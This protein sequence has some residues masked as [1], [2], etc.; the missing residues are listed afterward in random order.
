M[1]ARNSSATSAEFR[2]GRPSARAAGPEPSLCGRSWLCGVVVGCLGGHGSEM[3]RMVPCPG[4]E[5][6]LSVPSSVL[7]TLADVSQSRA[8]GSLCLVKPAAVV[9][10]PHDEHP[11]VV[12]Q[13]KFDLRGGACV[14]CDVLDRFRAAEVNGGLG[15]VGAARRGPCDAHPIGA[16]AACARSASARPS[17]TSGSG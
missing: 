5:A 3:V 8:V 4:V 17:L 7:D 16:R 10:D 15:F 13:A 1:A 6:S 14:F 12:L 9:F 11:V 2:Y